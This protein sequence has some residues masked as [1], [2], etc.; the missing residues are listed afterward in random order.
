MHSH[1]ISRN[2]TFLVSLAFCL[3]LIS[4]AQPQ[5]QNLGQ[6][7]L[8]AT[9]NA[10]PPLPLLAPSSASIPFS[11][12]QVLTIQRDGQS[13]Q[14][15][16]LLEWDNERIDIAILKLGR[17][18]ITIGYDGNQL[19]IQKDS[20]VPDDISGEQIL[21]DIQLVYWPAKALRSQLHSDYILADYDN[22]RVLFYK[23]QMLYRIQYQ[24]DGIKRSSSEQTIRLTQLQYGY[25]MTIIST[26][27]PQ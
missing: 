3:T 23:N 26:P 13:H 14:V 11:A 7:E 22:E 18:A 17:R 19:D 27:V 8:S 16:S 12:S 24:S 5:A 20:F 9:K 21:R 25:D 15:E 2:L 4:C 10:L 1:A 6:S